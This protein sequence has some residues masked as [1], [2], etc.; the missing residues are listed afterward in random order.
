MADRRG[1][2]APTDRG[3]RPRG[4]QRARRAPDARASTATP[5]SGE[6]AQ[7]RRRA[8][9]PARSSPPATKPP[10]RRAPAA[11]RS[12]P[13]GHRGGAAVRRCSLLGFLFAFV[14]PTRTY[15]NQRDQI[16]A[17][18]SRLDILQRADEGARGTTRSGSRATPRSSASPASSTGSSVR[19]RRRTCSCPRR[20]RRPRPRPPRPP[21]RDRRRRS[22]ASDA[23]PGARSPGPCGATPVDSTRWLPALPPTSPRCATGSVAT[24]RP[25]SR[26]SCATPT[27]APVVLR[28]AP[29]T[30]DGTPMPTRYWLVD[31]GART[32]RRPARGRRGRAAGRGGGRSRPSSPPPTPAT[33]PSATPRSPPTTRGPDPPAAS[34]GPARA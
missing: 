26:S 24:R 10:N 2:S 33:R 28:N 27:G 29:F 7:T 31:P 3:S 19:A 14:Y 13:L 11:S 6:A 18:Q 17:P 4:G 22:P 15:L 32:A 25:T 12:P 1:A 8:R 16:Q 9:R 5:R 21:R 23:R 20:R 34:A 30:R